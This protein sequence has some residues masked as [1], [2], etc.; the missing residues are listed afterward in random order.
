MVKNTTINKKKQINSRYVPVYTESESTATINRMTDQ[1]FTMTIGDINEQQFTKRTDENGQL[2]CP[3]WSK[4]N[5]QQKKQIHFWYVPEYTE[6]ESTAT[7]NQMTDQRFTMTIGDI[8]EQQFT[9]RTDENGQL[10]GLAWSK[11]TT[12]NKKKQIYSRYVPEYT[13]SESTATI[14]Q[15]TDQRF[16]MTIGD[17][18]KQQFTKRTDENGKLEGPAWS[19][20]TNNTLDV[21]RNT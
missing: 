16:T 8:N 19:K 3:A 5:N 20:Q 13:E 18:N 15:M 9:K 4:H 1:R 17:I 7:I 6:S 2:E 12:I 14:N 21:P 10:E 11:H